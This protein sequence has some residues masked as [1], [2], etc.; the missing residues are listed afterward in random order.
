MKGNLIWFVVGMASC[1]ALSAMCCCCP[2]A[3]EWRERAMMKGRE[4]KRKAQE[5]WEHFKRDAEQ[6]ASD[7]AQVTQE[8][9]Q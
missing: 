2:R 7:M 1:A 4:A 9:P 6:R 3:R 8:T 5:A